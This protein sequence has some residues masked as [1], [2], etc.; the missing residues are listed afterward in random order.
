MVAV[1]QHRDT[2]E[3][4]VSG[5]CRWAP[6]EDH[7][8]ILPFQAMTTSSRSRAWVPLKRKLQKCTIVWLLSNPNRIME[9]ATF[10][11][12]CGLNGQLLNWSGTFP[13]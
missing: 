1:Y 11:E 4:V 13:P 10:T 8:C 2:S 9:N 12:C 5:D 3:I 6:G 7:K